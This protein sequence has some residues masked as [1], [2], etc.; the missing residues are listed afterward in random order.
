MQ[1]FFSEYGA[2]NFLYPDAFEAFLKASDPEFAETVAEALKQAREDA[3][4]KPR[5]RIAEKIAS[6]ESKKVVR[7]P[8][9][10]SRAK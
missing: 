1:V 2:R 5:R 10:A 4:E 9:R 3:S 6:I 7:K 8:A